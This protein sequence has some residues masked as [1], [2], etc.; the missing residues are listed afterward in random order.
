MI[1]PKAGAWAKIKDAVFSM[2]QLKMDGDSIGFLGYR[3]NTRGIVKCWD[4]RMGTYIPLNDPIL[5]SSMYTLLASYAR[6]DH[7]QVI[8][9]DEASFTKICLLDAS[10]H[11][12]CSTNQHRIESQLLSIVQNH[13]ATVQDLLQERFNATRVERGDWAFMIELMPCIL[14]L[15]VYHEGIGYEEEKL[16]MPGDEIGPSLHLYFE[17]KTIVHLPGDYSIVRIPELLETLFIN[18]LNSFL[19]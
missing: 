12:S 3:V 11:M 2:D 14:A 5:V 16:S 10:M 7:S 13:H 19:A 1:P 17:K 18:S 9:E 15:V 8:S 6:G 4:E